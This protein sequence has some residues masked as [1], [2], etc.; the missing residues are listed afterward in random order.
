[1]AFQHDNVVVCGVDGSAASDNALIWAAHEAKTRN[2]VLDIVCCHQVPSYPGQRGEG[3]LSEDAARQIIEAARAKVVGT[4]VDVQTSLESDDPR[5]VLLGRSKKVARIVVGARGGSGGFA[6]RLLGS[7]ASALTSRAYCAVVVVPQIDLEEL[8]PAKHIVCGVDG[9]ETSR[10]ALELAIREAA[11]W[12]A[13]LSCVSAINLGGS[14]W[15]PG[16]GYHQEVIDDVRSGLNEAVETAA[17]GYDVDVHCHVIEGN[18]AAL[19]AEFSTAVDLLVVG[20]R[21]RGGFAGLLLGSTS[22]AVLHHSECPTIV[23]PRR[24]GVNEDSPWSNV[25]WGRKK[26]SAE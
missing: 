14:M 12:G 11:R 6:D 26:A 7:V 1:M 25:P 18:P 20:T 19:L 16:P 23:V 17:E 22:Q 10:I 21:G 13:K 9:S 2:A 24:T 4:G 15:V 5:S 8:V 3:G